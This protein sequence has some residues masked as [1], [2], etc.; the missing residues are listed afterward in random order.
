MALRSK[1]K[2][3]EP[4]FP[5]GDDEV[6]VCSMSF[7]SDLPTPNTLVQKMTRL[8]SSNP[9][10]RQHP[11]HFVRDGDPIPGHAAGD[12]SAYDDVNVIDQPRLVS[13]LPDSECV[14]ATQA[15]SYAIGLGGVGGSHRIGAMQ[16]IE[17]GDRLHKGDEAV[18][19]NPQFFRPAGG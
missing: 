3:K 17:V 6:V 12:L 1:P 7:W 11:Y 4:A 13:E 16:M 2:P 5:F 14:I 18:T 9:I 10:V 15:F 8:R 19:R